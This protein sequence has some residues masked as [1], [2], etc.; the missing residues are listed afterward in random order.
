VLFYSLSRDDARVGRFLRFLVA[1]MSEGLHWARRVIDNVL[2]LLALLALVGGI[3]YGGV[4]LNKPVWFI[5]GLVVV[6][7]V[8]VFGRGTY[9][10]WSKADAA[11]VAVESKA[12]SQ[13]D[14]HAAIEALDNERLAGLMVQ[15][16][17][18]RPR[19]S[20]PDVMRYET[21]ESGQTSAWVSPIP[22]PPENLVSPWVDRV[23][24]KLR[25]HTIGEFSRFM[26]MGNLDP[27]TA[28][29][30]E[31]ISQHLRQLDAI[32]NALRA[33]GSERMVRHVEP[34]QSDPDA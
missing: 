8:V 9:E 10:V 13:A 7:F 27:Q 34:E 1:A 33:P 6:A 31:R 25:R 29:E 14:V 15:A 23:V 18:R 21:D 2:L 12:A 28:S 11:R 32:I 19:P 16:K 24:R 20:R 17:V 4:L 5:A 3:V 30:Y 22:L 26:D